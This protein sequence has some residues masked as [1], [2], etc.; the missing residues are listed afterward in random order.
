MTMPRRRHPRLLPIAVL[1]SAAC[2]SSSTSPGEKADQPPAVQAGL[3]LTLPRA[4]PKVGEQELKVTEM[5]MQMRFDVQGRKVET[6]VDKRTE[7]LL[8][9]V[10]VD[11]FAVSE[12]EVTYKSIRETSE[13]A[14]KQETKDDP[15]AGKSYRL[16]RQNGVL[17][18]R[19]IGGQATDEELE[20]VVDDNDEIGVPSEIDAIVA[21]KTWRSGQ[22]IAFTAAEIARVNASKPTRPGDDKETITAME[23]TLLASKDG[24]AVFALTM[25][26]R[27]DSDRGHFT[28]TLK[29]QARIDVATGRILELGGKGQLGGKVQGMPLDGS[30]TMKGASRWVTAP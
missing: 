27:V 10:A 17:V 15:R 22:P 12:A 11:G 1:L 2:S 16:T 7:E 5:R 8:K 23:L 28:V 25:G 18:A 24:V 19:P 9:V 6:S 4:Q 3:E 26:F 21:S 14:G 13:M 30:M 29:G 20:E